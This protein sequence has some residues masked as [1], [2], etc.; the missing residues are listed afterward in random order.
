MK[1]LLAL[2]LADAD[3]DR[4]RR[5][6]AEAITELQATPAAGARVLRG[7]E[8]ADGIDTPVAHGLPRA[9]SFVTCSVPRGAIA[10]GYLEEV[11]SG[12][13]RRAVVL[14]ATGYG[15]TVTVD[16]LVLP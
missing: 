3:A 9:P 7:V 2:T 15:A 11:R 10:A 12:T 4:V 13:D 8:L 5:N 1:A 6:H 16:V 14:R